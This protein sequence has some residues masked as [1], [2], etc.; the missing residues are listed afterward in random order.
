M[1]HI[2]HLFID[3]VISFTQFCFFFLVQDH[4]LSSVVCL[5]S[6]FSL[7]SNKPLLFSVLHD[8]DILQ[9][10]YL[11]CRQLCISDT[12]YQPRNFFFFFLRRQ[13]L[14]IFGEITFLSKSLFNMGKKC[15]FFRKKSICFDLQLLFSHR[16]SFKLQFFHFL[17]L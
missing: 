14:N 13:L 12:G 6:Q 2:P 17:P 16:L 4:A 8:I 3:S 5:F 15:R 10:Y 9:I 1:A 7:I 11:C